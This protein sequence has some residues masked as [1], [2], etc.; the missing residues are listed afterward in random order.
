MAVVDAVIAIIEQ[1]V[2][3][4]LLVGAGVD[5]GISVVAGSSSAKMLVS[6]PHVLFHIFHV[7]SKIPRHNAE[8][9]EVFE[10]HVAQ[11]LELQ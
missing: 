9:N 1:Q 5:A 11:Q 3:I 4:G 8:S 10:R 7:K 6:M 2:G